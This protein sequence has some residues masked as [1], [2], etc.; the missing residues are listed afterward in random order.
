[1]VAMTKANV[2]SLLEF[3]EV[4]DEGGE[5]GWSVVVV[6]FEDVEEVY[7]CAEMHSRIRSTWRP[8]CTLGWYRSINVSFFAPRDSI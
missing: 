3:R 6:V 7:D 2:P 8:R 4:F 5:D 1:M